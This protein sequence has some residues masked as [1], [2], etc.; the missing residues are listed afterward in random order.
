[1]RFKTYELVSWSWE[2]I[3]SYL[4][5]YAADDIDFIIEHYK[6]LNLLLLFACYKIGNFMG[7]CTAIHRFKGQ[8]WPKPALAVYPL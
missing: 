3:H 7:T 5:S 2:E 1:M 8:K 4:A 6:K